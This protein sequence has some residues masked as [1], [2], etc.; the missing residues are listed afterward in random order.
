[1]E[2]QHEGGVEPPRYGC[3]VLAGTEISRRRKRTANLRWFAL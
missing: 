3:G 2:L 1:M